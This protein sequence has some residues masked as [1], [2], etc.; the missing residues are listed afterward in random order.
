MLGSAVVAADNQP[1][2]FSPGVAARCRLADGRR[3][4]I[5]A[6]SPA[7]NP[8]SPGMHR[9]EGQIASRL[10][11]GLPVPALLGMIDDGEWV[12]LIFEEIEGQPPRLPWSI[13]DL[14]STSAALDNLSRAATPCPVPGLPTFAERHAEMFGGYRRLAEGHPTTEVIDPWSR[15]HLDHLAALEAEWESAAAGNS[16]VHSDLRADNLLVA[17]DGAV[18]VVDWPH[19]CVGA[20]WLDVACMLP[21]VGLDGGPSPTEVERSLNP[22]AGINP[23]AIDRVLVGLAGYFTFQGNQADPPGL[24][25]VRRFQRAQGHVTRSWLAHRLGLV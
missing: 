3:C 22:L 6:V 18:V 20:A 14:A 5:K 25:T 12:V 2:G 24:P 23:D 17:P 10:P 9:K 15:T 1:G 8:E 4:F 21:S 16:L 19:A 13:A 11:A 7:Q